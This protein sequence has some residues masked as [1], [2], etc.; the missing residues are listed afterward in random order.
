MVTVNMDIA[1][2][3]CTAVDKF[4][5]SI[6]PSERQL[7]LCEDQSVGLIHK[8]TGGLYAFGPSK[9]FTY[10]KATE[11]H[12]AQRLIL[13]LESPHKAE[14]SDKENPRPAKGAT[15]T[16]IRKYLGDVLKSLAAPIETPLEVVLVN[17]V[18][19]Q[20]SQQRKLTLKANKRRR[21][22]VFCHTFADGTEFMAR[23]K[24]YVREKDIIVNACTLGEAQPTL[25]SRVGK[26]LRAFSDSSVQIYCAPHPYRWFEESNRVMHKVVF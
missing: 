11:K 26:T 19:F 3:F 20:C 13:V 5:Q 24:E 6:P 10:R 21:D 15:G 23:I 2:N 25:N 7:G 8:T 9:Q 12:L 14:Y 18:T 4:W 17:A 16:N 22:D 1:K